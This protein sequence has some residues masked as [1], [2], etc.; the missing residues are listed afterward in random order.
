M[1]FVHII[2]IVVHEEF[3]N[4]NHTWNV[5]INSIILKIFYLNRRLIRLF[6]LFTD[7][8]VTRLRLIT[9]YRVIYKIRFLCSYVLC[10]KNLALDVSY[11]KW[12]LKLM[13]VVMRAEYHGKS[14]LETCIKR[15]YPKQN[16]SWLAPWLTLM[17]KNE[18]KRHGLYLQISKRLLIPKVLLN[19]EF[20]DTH[21]KEIHL[22]HVI[23][24]IML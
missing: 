22:I 9:W 23:M 18:Y 8:K 19:L 1:L 24:V 2:W 10:Q 20:S 4:L 3:V 14:A 13:F 17:L 16:S 5:K 6:S 12:K 21:V 15:H 7:L 11:G